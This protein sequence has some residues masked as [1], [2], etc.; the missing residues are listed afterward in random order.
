MAT[1][2][3]LPLSA[4]VNGRRILIPSSSFTSASALPIHTVPSSGSIDE[5]WLYAY[6]DATASLVCSIL[7]GGTTEPNDVFRTTILPQGGI[8]LI[9]D[10]QIIQSGLLSSMLYMSMYLFSTI[11][12][13]YFK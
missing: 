10:G 5:V 7:W 9:S 2:T 4:S 12:F 8:A 3:K 13:R 11:S 1:F 6:N